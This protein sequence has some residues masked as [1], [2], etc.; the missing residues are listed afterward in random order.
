MISV[1]SVDLTDLLEGHQLLV[2]VGDGPVN[3]EVVVSFYNDKDLGNPESA[4]KEAEALRKLAS[5]Y[6]EMKVVFTPAV[7]AFQ[8]G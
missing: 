6:C 7:E 4:R 3:I 2:P 5:E 8:K 1:P